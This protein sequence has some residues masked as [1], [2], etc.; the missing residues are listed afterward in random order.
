MDCVLW[1]LITGVV[2]VWI[3]YYIAIDANV[4]FWAFVA[5]SVVWTTVSSLMFTSQMEFFARLASV[6]P[7]V[8][9]SYMTLLNTVANLGGSWPQPTVLFFS[10]AI[11]YAYAGSYFLEEKNKWIVTRNQEARC[12]TEIR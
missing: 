9:G 11:C 5:L 1:R 10:F 3:V 7:S 4:A 12:V 6:N 2:D 8:G